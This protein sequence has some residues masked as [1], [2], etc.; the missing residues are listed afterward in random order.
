MFKIASTTG[1]GWAKNIQ[2]I[3]VI[4]ATISICGSC[5][6]LQEIPRSLSGRSDT[7]DY[8][9]AGF[10]LHAD[11]KQPEIKKQL[12]WLRQH[13][14]YLQIRMQSARPYLYFVVKQTRTRN[15]PTELALMPIIESGFNP[16]LI[17][18]AG[19][20]GLWQ[21]MPGT[22][23]GF[24]LQINWW[25]DGR[26]DIVQS[27]KAALNYLN[28]LH[29]FL[30]NWLLAIAAYDSGEG[31]VLAAL[32]HNLAHQLPTDIWSLKLPEETHKYVARLLAIQIMI[33]HPQRY[34]L[35]LPHINTKATFKAV[36]IKKQISLPLLARLSKCNL[37]TL[38]TFNPAYRREII[39][40]NST[41][42]IPVECL[43]NYNENK[44]YAN[45]SWVHYKVKPGDTVSELAVR[46]HSSS[47]AIIAANKLKTTNLRIGQILMIPNLLATKA[48]FT[49]PNFTNNPFAED[50]SPGPKQI[51]YITKTGD[52]LWSI[53][54][55]FNV[56]SSEIRYWNK[57][58]HHLKPGERITIWLSPKKQHTAV[59]KI[60][61][62]DT[63][64]L[65]AYRS[66]VSVKQLMYINH[67][68]N[69][70]I[71]IGKKIN[72]PRH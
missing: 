30:G 64:S 56:R 35:K 50:N 32:R 41:A 65:I 13:P 68:Q 55:K 11:P 10:R 33:N 4:I 16:L 63:L 26:R 60:K 36:K 43:D 42:L 58:P 22:A 39:N 34:L 70:K 8:L 57:L 20:S 3:T 61:P 48:K 24:G 25:Y 46:Y 47:A 14:R 62:G 17:S 45:T 21:I 27:T 1:R 67:L 23:S 15:M 59:Y 69:T 71:H 29:S 19:A 66:K 31:T 72:I 44:I 18:Q 38:T 9:R 54:K 49:R 28:Y 51:T 7:W 52:S 37:K 6:L 53:A 12:K 2:I 5:S 40:A